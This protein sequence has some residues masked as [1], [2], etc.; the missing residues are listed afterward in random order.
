[1]SCGV[2]ATP[3]DGLPHD[4]DQQVGHHT[5]VEGQVVG[6]HLE[7]GGEGEGGDEGEKGGR[8]RNNSV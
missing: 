1:M 4:G 7:Q 3:V 6:D 8:E 2:P 5:G